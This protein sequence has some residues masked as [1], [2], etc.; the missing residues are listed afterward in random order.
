MAT[1]LMTDI[2]NYRHV[3][4]NWL[5]FEGFF[6]III[7]INY[8]I[9]CCQIWCKKLNSNK[10]GLSWRKSCSWRENLKRNILCAMWHVV[11]ITENHSFRLL[12]A[13]LNQKINTRQ[14]A[15]AH[16][17]PSNRWHNKTKLKL[18]SLYN[19]IEIFDPSHL[20]LIPTKLRSQ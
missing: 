20:G 7:I 3:V 10:K 15:S 11:K 8:K 1:P 19:T 17:L 13:F 16:Q 6:F 2:G 4:F 5:D 18:T 12:T 9:K 14:Y